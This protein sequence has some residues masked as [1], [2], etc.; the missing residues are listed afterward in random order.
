MDTDINATFSQGSYDI[1]RSF[2][3]MWNFTPMVATL[4]EVRQHAPNDFVTNIKYADKSCAS[5]K[6]KTEREACVQKA[7]QTNFQDLEKRMA[8][9]QR[10]MEENARIYMSEY[11]PTLPEQLAPGFA[12]IREALLPTWKIFLST[13]T[14]LLISGSA[15]TGRLPERKRRMGSIYTTSGLRPFRESAQWQPR[16]TRNG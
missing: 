1:A 7:M 2:E 16:K 10:T 9:C 14:S 12:R 13:G 3:D 5:Q 11:A 8:D 15:H 6:G 4:T